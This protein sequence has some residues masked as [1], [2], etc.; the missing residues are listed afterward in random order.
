M[1]ERTSGSSHEIGLYK[2]DP[3]RPIFRCVIVRSKWPLVN[4][5]NKCFELRNISQLNVLDLE[6]FF[7]KQYS[8]LKS[9]YII[10]T[11]SAR[12]STLRR[13]TDRTQQ[14]VGFA[15]SIP[16]QSAR[17]IW[18]RLQLIVFAKANRIRT[19]VALWQKEFTDFKFFL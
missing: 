9:S 3:N 2:G 18:N 19:V 16:K 15:P 14:S 5:I 6:Y 4:V 8:N 10:W 1:R 13:W 7:N 11:L 17:T 12:Y